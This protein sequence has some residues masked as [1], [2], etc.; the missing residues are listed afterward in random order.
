M[1]V[2]GIFAPFVVPHGPEVIDPSARKCPP[3]SCADGSRSHVLGTDGLGR[4]VLSGI[5]T[6]LRFHVYIGLLGS[7]L[8]LLAAWLLIT[9]RNMMTTVSGPNMMGPLLGVPYYSMAILTYLVGAFLSLVVIAGLGSSFWLVIGCAGVVSSIL[10]MVLVYEYTRRGRASSS[11]VQPVIRG[12]MALYPV[13][14]ALAFLMG[15]FI[16][17]SLSFLGVGMPPTV[18]SL[19]IMISRGID[20]SGAWI[21]GFPL[22]VVLVGTGAFL[23]IVFPVSRDFIPTSQAHSATSPPIQTGMPAGFWIRLAAWS[24]DFAISVFLYVMVRLLSGFAETILSIAFLAALLGIWVVSPGK[25]ALRLDVLRPD[26]SSVGLGRKFCRSMIAM[27]TFGIGHFMV[28][29]RQDK[30]GIHDL[31]ADTV[32]VRGGRDGRGVW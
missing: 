10:P 15:I 12:G 31:L 27:L 11:G 7:I 22:S 32:V 26:G 4:D 29:L 19:G 28:G 30:R 25:R 16:E 6:S 14:F 5:V 13:G 8:G 17:S 3:L 1:A 20:F 23:A 2:T 9:V 18:S 24:I 21:A